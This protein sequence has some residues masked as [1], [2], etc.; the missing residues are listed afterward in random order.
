M[1]RRRREND[2]FSSLNCSWLSSNAVHDM[3]IQL[4]IV[5]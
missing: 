5:G 2:E 1:K 3:Q 4:K